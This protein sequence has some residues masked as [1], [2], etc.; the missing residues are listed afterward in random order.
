MNP[1]P[2]EKMPL[3]EQDSPLENLLSVDLSKLSTEE[4]REH[5]IKLR[6]TASSSQATKEAMKPKRR[7]AVPQ[8]AK[9]EAFLDSIINHKPSE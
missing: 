9:Q 3:S 5:V 7:Q 6:E 2:S 1:L 4:L 8:V